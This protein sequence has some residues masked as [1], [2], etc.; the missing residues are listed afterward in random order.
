MS[1]D[2]SQ[3]GYIPGPTLAPVFI[4]PD[5]C[6][7]TVDKATK[8]ATCRRADH[9]TPTS[10]CTVTAAV[11][12]GDAVVCPPI[13]HADAVAD[14][15][16]AYTVEHRRPWHLSCLWCEFETDGHRTKREAMDAMSEHYAI[17]TGVP[18]WRVSR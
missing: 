2:Y 7:L 12:A 6:L 1:A 14:T 9:P 5:E 3:G 18:G 16:H 4:H 8:R 13:D 15:G 11:P 10:D 17:V